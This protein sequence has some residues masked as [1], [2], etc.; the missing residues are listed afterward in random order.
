M[1]NSYEKGDRNN[2]IT[3]DGDIAAFD[4]ERD[5]CVF[6][7]MDVKKRIWATAVD[8]A[9]M[10]LLGILC[11]FYSILLLF[12]FYLLTFTVDDSIVGNP[13]QY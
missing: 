6:D 12:V 4:V 7:L 13:M 2:G 10:L 8:V 5:E 11:F 3:K 1:K 9:S